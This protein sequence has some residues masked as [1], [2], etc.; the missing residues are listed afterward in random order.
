VRALTSEGILAPGDGA[1]LASAHPLVGDAVLAALGVVALARL[2]ERTSELLHEA[3][4]PAARISAHLLL[5]EPAGIA[6]HAEVLWVA[7]EEALASG[8]ES[9]AI[10]LA[11]RALRESLAGEERTRLLRL[12]GVALLSVGRAADAARA[13]ERELPGLADPMERVRRLMDIGDARYADGDYESAEGAYRRSHEL[14]EG[15]GLEPESALAL[16]HAARFATARLTISP[17]AQVIRADALRAV[18]RR[19]ALSHGREERRFLAAAALSAHTREDWQADPEALAVRAFGGGAF[20][21]DGFADDPT[22][23]ALSGS[24]YLS[25]RFDDALELLDRA[26]EDARRRHRVA[27]EI[28]ARSARGTTRILTGSLLAGLDDLDASIGLSRLG[29]NPLLFQVSAFVH[30]IRYNGLVGDIDR[31]NG[32]V[33][34]FSAIEL[35]PALRAM[36][37]LG[38][39]E[40]ALASGS[41]EVAARA[42]ARSRELD[43][44]GVFAWTFSWRGVAAAAAL[45]LGDPQ[46]AAELN[47]EERHHLVRRRIPLGAH[48]DSV[49]LTA[50]LQPDP[51]A[52]ATLG[53]FLDVLPESHRWQR[54]VV[55]EHLGRLLL[56]LRPDE[57]HERLLFALS[58]ALEEGMLPLERRVRQALRQLGREPMPSSLERRMRTLT[59]SEL[60]VA[61][62]AASG[63]SNRDI[64]RE[65]FVTLK[66]V[67]FH[68]ART[69]R[70][71]GVASRR[72]LG[73]AFAEAGE[74][75]PPASA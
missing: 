71:L 67:E 40:H 18:L 74:I 47:G 26:V 27:S 75:A 30:L 72:E 44:E 15:L 37:L 1:A 29:A 54:A 66:T 56:D 53:D 5:T 58:V 42:A 7:A 22:T 6:W 36:Q 17:L 43:S 12:L 60:R 14:L 52:R 11:E 70:K 34:E 19:P 57:A 73:A 49:L 69:Y 62:R 2:R 33:A 9:E 35:P 45:A 20:V 55:A 31:S 65:L 25:G 39:A 38:L 61:S 63:L 50:R 48:L 28:P 64:A 32:L 59:V 51:E 23:Y 8:A 10:T 24:L 41:P 13:W 16:E 46:R 21:V 4:V 3:G 68:L